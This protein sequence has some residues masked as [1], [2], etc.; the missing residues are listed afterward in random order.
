MIKFKIVA[1][2]FVSLFSSQSFA[3]SSVVEGVV[4]KSEVITTEVGRD[5]HPVLG[6]AVGVGI[7]SAFGSGSGNDAA[8]IAGGL[9]GAR[10]AAQKQKEVL[11]G[12]RYI[13]KAQD[14]LHV[15]DAW[16][17]KPNQQCSGV[18]EG[19]EVYIINNNEVVEK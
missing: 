1:L 18:L 5:G 6:A 9:I 4:E 15:V 13:V 12:W 10:R 8:K 3:A 11:Y 16:C 7:G 14:E 17:A 2:V 19:K